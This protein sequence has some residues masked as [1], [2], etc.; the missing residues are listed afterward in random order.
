MKIGDSDY[1]SILE[2]TLRPVSCGHGVALD[3]FAGC[4]GLGLGF[5]AAGFDTIGFEMDRD[6]CST[7]NANL[8]GQC[9]E[10]VLT[11]D[12]VFP[13]ADIVIGGPPCQPFSVG[14]HQLGLDDSRDGFPVFIAAVEQLKPRLWM[15]ENVRGLLYRNRWYL[16]Q[17]VARLERIG[18]VVEYHLLNAVHYGVPQNRE[19]I[20][21]A[22]HLGGFRFPEKQKHLVSAGSA[23]GHLAYASPED[24]KYLTPSMDA[25]V[26]KYERASKCI[27]PRDLHLD[28]PAR[29]LT[30]RNLAGATGDM[31]RIRQADGRRRRL[32]PREAARLQ[33]FPDWF[34]FHGTETSQF[35]QIGNAVPPL[36][37]RAL[38]DSVADYLRHGRPLPEAVIRSRWSRQQARLELVAH[39]MA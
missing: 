21:V 24:A 2:E 35:N 18:Y 31:Q 32:T 22:G 4:G 39:E 34:A 3:L 13:Q 29:T 10:V 20:I 1:G 5:E 28:R 11:P 37:A 33:S 38:A 19:R 9:H 8:N 25:Y 17:I 14:G 16:D 7:Y 30:C 15:F 6:C 36:F 26:A 12:Y 23:L 27:N